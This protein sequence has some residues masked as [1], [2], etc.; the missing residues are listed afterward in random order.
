ML[1]NILFAVAGIREQTFPLIDNEMLD[2][3]FD[4][5]ECGYRA[6]FTS[7]LEKWR[8]SELQ[9]NDEDDIIEN[10]PKKV[11]MLKIP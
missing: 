2:V 10:S 6:Q 8:N 11:Q 4:K 9:Q 7:N 1:F 5:I 3:L